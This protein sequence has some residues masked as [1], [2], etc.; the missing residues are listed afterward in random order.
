MRSGYI[1]ILG[2]PNAGKSTLLNRILK[3]KLSI[4]SDKPQT[5]RQRLIGIY[6]TP[7][8]QMIFLDTP[9]IHQSEKLINRYMMD[10]V[11]QSVNSADILCYLYSADA[12]ASSFFADLIR[13]NHKNNPGKK[14]VLAINKIDLAG[15]HQKNIE[16]IASFFSGNEIFRISALKNTGVTKLTDKLESL[17]PEGPAYYPMDEFT[18]RNLRYLASE[19]IREKAMEAT[20][21]EIPYSIAVEIVD[22]REEPAI[23]RIT[24]NIVVEHESQKGMVIGSGGR[25]IK[26]IGTKARLDIEKLTGKVFLDLR[27]KVDKNWTKNPAKMARYGYLFKTQK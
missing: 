8:C 27:V 1:A 7:S 2:P 24:A 5:T 18:D 19:I 3:E 23:T 4:V 15:D 14:S 17:L 10:E 11:N 16:D 22:Y 20:W 26:E 12:P 6:N 9:G 21:H 13:R 25:L